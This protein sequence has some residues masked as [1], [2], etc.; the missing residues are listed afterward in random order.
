M[1]EVRIVQDQTVTTKPVD[2]SE[3][4]KRR[5]MLKY[6]LKSSGDVKT[7]VKPQNNMSFEDMVKM[8][9]EERNRRM[10]PKVDDS[11]VKFVTEPDSG[12]T[13]EI[14]V[15]SNMDLGPTNRYKKI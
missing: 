1:P 13:V 12:L 8:E 2:V 6:G 9:E 10:K 3:S 11:G 5:L 14:K 4:E 15:T 7:P